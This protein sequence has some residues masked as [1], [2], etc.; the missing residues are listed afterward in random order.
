VG[1]RFTRF[2]NNRQNKWCGCSKNGCFNCGDP[3]RFVASCPKKDKSKAGPC[4]HHS[5]RCKGKQEY[6]S[7][8]HKCKGGFNKEVLK[9]STPKGK[10][11]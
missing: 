2:H 3:N 7:I 9:I 11:Q 6:N 4:N 10:D 5:G 8:K 1:S